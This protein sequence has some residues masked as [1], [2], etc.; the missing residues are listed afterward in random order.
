M[1]AAVPGTQAIACVPGAIAEDE[2]VAHFALARH[3]FASVATARAALPD[4]Y[5]FKFPSH[6][7]TAI[8][9]FVTNER[10]CCPFMQFDISVAPDAGP[11]SLRMTGPEGTR[12]VLDA[13]LGL[14]ACSTG[15]CGCHGG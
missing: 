5:E 7:I 10:K 1:S 4:G 11:V 6:S 8:A 13:E 15:G 2:R 12:A 3:L 9:Q 14:S